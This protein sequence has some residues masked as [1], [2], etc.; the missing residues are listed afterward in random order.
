[1]AS[2]WEGKSTKILQKVDPQR[3]QSSDRFLG[4]CLVDL[5]SDFGCQDE[6]KTGPRG[7]QDG[8]RGRQVS[9]KRFPKNGSPRS[10]SVFAAKTPQDSPKTPPRMIFDPFLID[11]LV[12]FRS[13]LGQFVV[14]FCLIFD[15][16]FDKFLERILFLFCLFFSLSLYT[17][18]HLHSSLLR[19]GIIQCG[20]KG[21]VNPSLER[22]EDSLECGLWI[23]LLR[24]R[25]LNHL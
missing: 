8:P 4:R 19:G 25:P 3:H 11:F 15:Q 24:R 13:L 23:F 21:G 9:P 1:M 22:L 20:I 14:D 7:R 2:F 18:L 6:P 16:L 10:W 12:D 5:G 17:N